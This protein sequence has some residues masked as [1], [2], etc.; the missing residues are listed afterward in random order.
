MTKDDLPRETEEFIKRG[1]QFV[2]DA[3]QCE[4]GEV[5][6]KRHDELTLS[7][8]YVNSEQSPIQSED[9]HA[10]DEGYYIVRAVDLVGECPAYGAEG[11]LM[12][13]PDY[14]VFGTWDCDHW[15]MMIFPCSSWSDI[16]ANPARYMAAQ[17]GPDLE[18]GEYL[19]PWDKC[20]FKQG[21]PF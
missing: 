3:S 21:K 19:K 7:E 8:V 6:L 18:I 5:K 13:L 14:K 15:D 10:N 16:V 2:Y 12:W 1:E 11:I 17:W 9:P 20:K 4:A